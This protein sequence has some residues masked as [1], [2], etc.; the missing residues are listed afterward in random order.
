MTGP[1]MS[2]VPVAMA[3]GIFLAVTG[4][5]AAHPFNVF[6]RSD[7]VTLTVQASI[8]DGDAPSEG[9]VTLLNGDNVVVAKTE[10][11]G[12]TG[13][14]EVT[15]EGLDLT[16]GVRAEVVSGGHSDYWVLTPEDLARS[17]SS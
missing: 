10:L 14:A 1:R 17:C 8:N 13:M 9:A 5:A 12:D 11:V 3:A 16:G 6:A 7:C 15:L 4:P 2:A